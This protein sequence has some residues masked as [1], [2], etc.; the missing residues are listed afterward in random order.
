MSPRSRL[1]ACKL[2]RARSSL[3]KSALSGAFGFVLGLLALDGVWLAWHADTDIGSA[4]IDLL[5]GDF[6]PALELSATQVGASGD[7]LLRRTPARRHNTRRW[8]RAVDRLVRPLRKAPV[9]SLFARVVITYHPLLRPC[10]AALRLAVHPGCLDD[11]AHPS[12][13]LA[14]GLRVRPAA[15]LKARRLAETRRGR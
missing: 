9:R 10:A 1:H 5:R 13:H 8:R 3:K 6:A 14:Q 4:L 12:A 15:S 2:V 7:A 11:Q